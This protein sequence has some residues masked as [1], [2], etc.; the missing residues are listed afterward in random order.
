MRSAEEV[1]SSARLSGLSGAE[2]AERL[3]AEGPNELLTA[4]PRRFLAVAADVVREP[5]IRLLLVCA[6]VY[7]VSGD[8]AEA[9]ALAGSIL[10]V[11]GISVYQNR[12]AERALDALRDLSAP[13]ARVL[14]GGAQ[15]R[16]PARDVVRGD[17]LFVA[18]GDRVPADAVLLR[19]TN[20]TVDESLLTGES[21]PVRKV[22]GRETAE[23]GTPGG[24]DTPFVFSGTLVVTGDG[25][26]RVK[27]TGARTR[28]GAIG[29]ALATLQPEETVLESRIRSLVRKLAL[30]G[31]GLCLV[32]AVLHGLARRDLLGGILAGLALAMAMLPEE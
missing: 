5:L 29:K 9:L 31:V 19:A 28:I 15:A 14:R 21:L 6:S 25:T 4:K 24:E 32:L 23:L 1:V 22:A 10:L 16:I 27:A 7:R 26:A 11:I 8:L 30:A 3:R 13:R 12:K 20:V 2:A 17:L 18:E